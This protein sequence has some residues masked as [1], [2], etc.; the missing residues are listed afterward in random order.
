MIASASLDVALLKIYGGFRNLGF[1]LEANLL[2]SLYADFG[3]VCA[4]EGG[5]W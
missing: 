3:S 1:E 2:R 5:E 4:D